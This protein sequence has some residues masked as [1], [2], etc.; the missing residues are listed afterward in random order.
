MCLVWCLA[1]KSRCD[2]A[3]FSLLMEVVIWPGAATN[4]MSDPAKA[5][6]P[7]KPTSTL[8]RE[9]RS[10]SPRTLLTVSSFS[11]LPF[12]LSQ[13]QRNAQNPCI[14]VHNFDD[15]LNLKKIVADGYRYVQ[16]EGLLQK[17]DAGVVTGH[18]M[19]TNVTQDGHVHFHNAS[20][21][22]LNGIQKAIL[23][24]QLS[25]K[26]TSQFSVVDADLLASTY[27]PSYSGVLCMRFMPTEH[28]RHFVCVQTITTIRRTAHSGRKEVG[29]GTAKSHLPKQAS[30]LTRRH[31]T[32]I[33]FRHLVIP[34]IMAAR[35]KV[36]LVGLGCSAAKAHAAP[37]A[38]RTPAR[39]PRTAIS[40]TP[41]AH[42][43]TLCPTT[44]HTAAGL[45]TPAGALPGPSSH[46][47]LLSPGARRPHPRS[48]L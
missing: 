31:F 16:V 29:W 3:R 37:S 28:F 44:T 38:A 2:S 4:A 9:G 33:G 5:T 6:V 24:T 46:G 40:R 7:T 45:A 1:L 14:S 41:S 22:I 39:S 42:S 30:I 26:S 43:R 15:T 32:R 25:S 10:H 13:F 17:P 18:F 19:H 21:A 23:Y 8:P 47:K 20:M 34:S 27:I 48:T 11:L 36:S 35:T 12:S